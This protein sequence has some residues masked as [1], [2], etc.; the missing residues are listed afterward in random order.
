[1][2]KTKAIAIPN[3]RPREK[4]KG[5]IPS[6]AAAIRQGLEKEKEQTN[7]VRAPFSDDQVNSLNS[8]QNSGYCHPF[9]CVCGRS[10][11]IA[12]Y[13]GWFCP[14]CNRIVQDWAHPFMANWNWKNNLLKEE[15]A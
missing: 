7:Y 8:F 9:T 4:K 6:R 1:M 14:K 10:D 15:Q 11:L 3:R 5:N 2:N 12:K 13:L